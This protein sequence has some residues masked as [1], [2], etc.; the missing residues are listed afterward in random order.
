VTVRV[1]TVD[2]HFRVLI[3]RACARSISPTFCAIT[4]SLCAMIGLLCYYLD[5]IWSV[6]YWFIMPVCVVVSSVL[7]GKKWPD[8]SNPIWTMPLVDLGKKLLEAAKL[9]QIETVKILLLNGAL[10]TTDWVYF[11]FIDWVIAV[12]CLA[13]CCI[14]ISVSVSLWNHITFVC[15]IHQNT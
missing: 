6:H 2:N 1:C 14:S 11:E 10:F 4:A 12:C 15:V 13:E 3:C 7:V 8:D 9:G 5:K